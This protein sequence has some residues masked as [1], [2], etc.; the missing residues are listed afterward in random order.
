MG[1]R[2]GA[3]ESL[4]VTPAPAACT[5]AFGHDAWARTAVVAVT[6]DSGHVIAA[7]LASV[8]QAAAIIVVDNASRDACLA[9][10]REGA[11]DADVI[12]NP[13]GRGFG[14]GVNQ[15]LERV[16]SEFALVINPDAVLRAG[17]LDAL[18]AGVGLEAALERGARDLDPPAAE[19]GAEDGQPGL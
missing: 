1:E 11:P 2:R 5:P 10:V 9:R 3:V 16:S 17:A 6:H 13:V 19:L 14:N 15:G 8:A 12:A 18:V 4:G 7:C